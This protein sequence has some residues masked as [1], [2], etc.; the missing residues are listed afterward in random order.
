[1]TF[2]LSVSN[3]GE[4][5]RD[6]AAGKPVVRPDR[7]GA[8]PTAILRRSEVVMENW[9][10]PILRLAA[11]AAAGAIIGINRDLYGKPTGVRLHALVTIGSALLVMLPGAYDGSGRDP[12]A[13]S[14]IIQGIVGGVGFLGAGV[15]LRA[16][17]GER[18]FHITTAATI[19]VTAAL[20][21]ACG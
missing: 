17:T 19:W 6:R 13:V 14:R 4:Y 12:A 16:N 15:I 20:G 5:N 9:L 1:M 21:I 2:R 18:V 8:S 10:E 11:A 3:L 7:C